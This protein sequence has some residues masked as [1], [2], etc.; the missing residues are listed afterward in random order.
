MFCHQKS[1]K[2][3]NDLKFMGIDCTDQG[4]KRDGTCPI[5]SRPTCHVLFTS[6]VLNYW[7]FW[8][9]FAK[10]NCVPNLEK[11]GSLL[12][13]SSNFSDFKSK[14]FNFFVKICLTF[15]FTNFK[16]FHL[17]A[18]LRQFWHLNWPNLYYP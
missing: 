9:I 3:R 8:N 1:P 14:I 15:F 6:L 11:G 10:N 18:I 12:L 13:D 2:N 17:S 16:A 5:P 4:C 7:K